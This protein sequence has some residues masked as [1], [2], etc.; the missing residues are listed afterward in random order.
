MV[1]FTRIR[2]CGVVT[3]NSDH[4]NPRALTYSVAP[5]DTDSLSGPSPWNE[6]HG[7]HP[8][9]LCD[10]EI[11]PIKPKWR[12]QRPPFSPLVTLILTELTERI[13]V[14]FTRTSITSRSANPSAGEMQ[15]TPEAAGDA[16]SLER[17][18]F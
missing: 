12:E 18:N 7:H 10:Y 8:Q 17:R 3:T 13:E 9:S 15:L 1:R 14:D 16:Y 11:Y 2:G 4:G 6:V 5:R